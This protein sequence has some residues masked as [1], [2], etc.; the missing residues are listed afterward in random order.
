[1]DYKFLTLLPQESAGGW[2]DPYYSC[3]SLERGCL[4]GRMSQ[5]GDAADRELVFN[6]WQTLQRRKSSFDMGLEMPAVTI[7]ESD[8]K[9]QLGLVYV[10]MPLW[11]IVLFLIVSAIGPIPKCI[12]YCARRKRFA[13]PQ[14]AAS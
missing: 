12:A 1:M 9:D 11:P 13:T 14:S 10:V 2:L 7:E 5:L 3:V 8:S 4:R 6:K